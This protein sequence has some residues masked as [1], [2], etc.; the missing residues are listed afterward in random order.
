MEVISNQQSD[1]IL[2]NFYTGVYLVC[3]YARKGDTTRNSAAGDFSQHLNSHGRLNLILLVYSLIMLVKTIKAE[4]NINLVLP[5]V[6][7]MLEILYRAF[8]FYAM[9]NLDIPPNETK[10]IVPVEATDDCTSP[11]TESLVFGNE[12][13][14]LDP[15]LKPFAAPYGDNLI[16]YIQTSSQQIII[17]AQEEI[18]H[19]QWKSEQVI[20]GI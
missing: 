7:S 6:L 1:P 5:S 14:V 11:V 15:V 13:P 18:Q 9:N 12:P 17:A 10:Y 20:G 2:I 3:V 19:Q 16:I 4:E 8:I